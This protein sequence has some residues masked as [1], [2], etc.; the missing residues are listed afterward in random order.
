MDNQYKNLEKRNKKSIQWILQRKRKERRGVAEKYVSE[1][2]VNIA[3][4]EKYIES[5]FISSQLL[6]KELQ[7]DSPSIPY[8][9][10]LSEEILANMSNA[11]TFEF[12]VERRLTIETTRPL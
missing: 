9:K 3:E 11:K 12:C 1:R 2:I 6:E 5:A 7:K 10:G 8:I 4:L